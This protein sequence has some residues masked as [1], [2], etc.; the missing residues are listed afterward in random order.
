MNDPAPYIDS[1]RLRL[2]GKEE[3]FA[4]EIHYEAAAAFR[5]AV[6]EARENGGSLREIGD[7]AGRSHARIHQI[8]R[9]VTGSKNRGASGGGSD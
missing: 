3:A 6:I 5:A 7:A 4:R 2:L 1:E 9:G 8:V